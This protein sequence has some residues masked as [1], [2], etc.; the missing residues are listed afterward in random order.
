MPSYGSPFVRRY[1]ISLVFSMMKDVRASFASADDIEAKGDPLLGMDF[2][3]IIV[4]RTS[5]DRRAFLA[6]DW[7]VELL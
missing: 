1:G 5:G 3:W 6:F 4:L 2:S 7:P